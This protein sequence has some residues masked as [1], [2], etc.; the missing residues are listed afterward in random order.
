MLLLSK[1]IGDPKPL[2]I[3]VH[4]ILKLGSRVD[5]AKVWI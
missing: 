1:R 5:I 2:I 3:L 4:Q